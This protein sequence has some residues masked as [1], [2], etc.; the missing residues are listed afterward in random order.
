MSRGGGGF[1]GENTCLQT[2]ILFAFD[3]EQAEQLDIAFDSPP[4]Y[5]QQLFFLLDASGCFSRLV[6]RE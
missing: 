6:G 2:L 4:S 3:S 1:N 5:T